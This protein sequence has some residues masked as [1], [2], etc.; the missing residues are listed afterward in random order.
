MGIKE[1]YPE[2]KGQ[3]GKVN[4][5]EEKT[6]FDRTHQLLRYHYN[7]NIYS[8]YNLIKSLEIKSFTLGNIKPERNH[9]KDYKWD[10]YFIM[11]INKLNVKY[12]SSWISNLFYILK[13]KNLIFPENKFCSEFFYN[14]YLIKTI[15]KVINLENEKLSERQNNFYSDLLGILFNTDLNEINNDNNYCLLDVFD[16]LG[17]S[18][19]ENNLDESLVDDPNYQYQLRRINVKK[20]IKIFKEHICNNADHPINQ[21][22]SL[23][24]KLFSQYIKTKLKELESQLL[25]KIINEAR[26]WELIKI[27]ENEVTESL[28]EFIT[29]IHS[30]V[31]LYYSTSID[32][33][34]FTEEK[35]D[36]MNMITTFIFRTGSLYE[37]IL[38]LYSYSFK[39]ELQIIQDKLVELKNIKPKKLGIEIKFCLDEDTIKLQNELRKN[40]PKNDF[41]IKKVE[42]NKENVQEKKQKKNSLFQNINKDNKT[43]KGNNLYTIKEREDEKDESIN[44][45]DGNKN[46]KDTGKIL[47]YIEDN[48]ILPDYNRPIRSKT[49]LPQL[50]KDDDY[51]LERLSFLED[52]KFE[53]NY[54]PAN[55]IRNSVNNFNNKVYFFPK[56]HTQLKKNLDLNENIKAFNKNKK[57]SDDILPIPYISAIKLLKSIKKYKTPFEKLLLIAA[58]SDQIMESATSFW[59]G[60]EPYI[61]KDYLFIEADEIMNIFLYIII[62]SQMPEVL[63]FCKIINNFTTQFTKAFNIAYNYT[64]L[65]A[66]LEY[67]SGLKDIHEINQKE[68]GFI[69][70]SK[71]IM[72]ISNQRISR[73]SLGIAQGNE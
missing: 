16:N 15:P 71:N 25:N 57:S 65:E 66:S 51:L 54:N 8:D 4:S 40:K 36:L 10:E 44:I 29:T 14:E 68:N 63:L 31:K 47:L 22:I 3:L 13:Q 62:Q 60:M 50:E 32:L 37:S 5:K 30:T 55:Q 19:L 46:D 7:I 21:I 42:E 17:G 64:L 2:I 41:D 69:D 56:L 48:K 43:K 49:K 61:D 73:L 20:Y 6:F 24:N 18:Y 12:H 33:T 72:N 35:D 58:I 11:Q 70:A 45:M 9:I 27:F 39:D 1:S 26:Y 59:K 34:F 52:S 23:F 67:I 53:N 38:D 28:Q